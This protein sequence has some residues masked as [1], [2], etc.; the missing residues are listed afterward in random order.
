MRPVPQPPSRKLRECGL[1]L[2]VSL[3]CTPLFSR[4]REMIKCSRPEGTEARDEGA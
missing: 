3:S 4:W 1:S 2:D